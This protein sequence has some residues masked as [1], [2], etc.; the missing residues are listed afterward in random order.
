MTIFFGPGKSDIE[1][2]MTGGLDLITYLASSPQKTGGKLNTVSC[3]QPQSD[4]REAII[5]MMGGKTAQRR[6]WSEARY[7]EYRLRER[8]RE[9]ERM[10]KGITAF[11]FGCRKYWR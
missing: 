7:S 8:G 3:Q 1:R 11:P 5:N 10:G 9:K 4:A 2:W 6:N